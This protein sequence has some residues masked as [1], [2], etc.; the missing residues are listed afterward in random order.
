MSDEEDEA[1]EAAVPESY[2]SPGRL[3]HRRRIRLLTD[4]ADL[5]C[6]KFRPQT[7]GTVAG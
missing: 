5:A 6:A 4:G 2:F 7:T 3:L 1:K